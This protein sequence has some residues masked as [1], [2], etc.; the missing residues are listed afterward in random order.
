M[1]QKDW[2][3]NKHSVFVTH[4]ATSHS[5]LIR[6]EGD[7]Y[8][9]DPHTTEI[10]LKKLKKDGVNLPNEITEPCCGEGHISEVLIK[11]GYKVDSYDLYDRGYGITGVDF[12]KSSLKAKCF[13]TNPPFKNSLDFVKKALENTKKDGGVI[14]LLRLQFLEGK[15]RNKFFKE[16]PPKYIYVNSTRQNCARNADFA[17]YE[18][19]TAMCFTWFIWKKGFKGEPTIR[20][21]D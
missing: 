2:T 6:P 10:F 3:G 5:N 13:F 14:M 7:F 8:A 4:G 19:A 17:T 16:H 12:L 15:E 9:T 11:H 18:K 1:I 21:V 20:W